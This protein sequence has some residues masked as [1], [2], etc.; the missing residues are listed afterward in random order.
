MRDDVAARLSPKALDSLAIRL[1]AHNGHDQCVRRLLLVSEPAAKES[2]A[3]RCAAQ[4]GHAE[5]V[6]LLLD[7]SDPKAKGSYAL[8]AAAQHGHA[9]CARLLLGV[10]GPLC[11]IG[12]LLEEVVKAGR[13]KMAALLIEHEPGLIY[14]LDLQKGIALAL[15]ND[16]ADMALFL[17]SIIEQ[18]DLL[19]MAPHPPAR[20]LGLSRL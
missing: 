3:L 8:R 20:S 4:N 5:C 13:S 2:E 17:S 14:G 19:G 10:P 18:R 9:E 15:E 1:A 7:A 11:E 6:R 16:H 12:G